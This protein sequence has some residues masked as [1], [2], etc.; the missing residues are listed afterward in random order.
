[1]SN[2]LYAILAELTPE[3]IIQLEV[4]NVHHRRRNFKI[5]VGSRLQILKK[6]NDTTM[7]S[8]DK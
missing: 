6:S 1:M 8:F 5:V 3:T 4:D 2:L 7:R